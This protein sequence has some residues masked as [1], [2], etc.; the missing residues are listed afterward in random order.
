MEPTDDA[1]KSVPKK[2]NRPIENITEAA[3]K[4]IEQDRILNHS[5][6]Q[7]AFNDFL[8]NQTAER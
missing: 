8:L 2:H 5:T 6:F 1:C 7:Y 4:S 3:L